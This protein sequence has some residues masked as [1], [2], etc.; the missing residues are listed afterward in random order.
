MG[1]YKANPTPAQAWG[2]VRKLAG[3]DPDAQA[4]RSPSFRTTRKTTRMRM[5]VDAQPLWFSGL[6][7]SVRHGRDPHGDI[8]GGPR[9]HR[10]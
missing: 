8:G 5:A 7:G 10:S 2:R 3:G 1:D 4:E 9:R 6:S